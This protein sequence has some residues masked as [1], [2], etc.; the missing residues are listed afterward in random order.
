MPAFMMQGHKGKALIMAD[1]MRAYDPTMRERMASALQGG[2]EGVGL[3]DRRGHVG[4]M[5]RRH[6]LGR[7]R[8]TGPDRDAPDPH[9]PRWIS[10]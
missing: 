7:D 2:M 6:A 10:L 9:G 3:R 5:R 1:E 4:R 8:V